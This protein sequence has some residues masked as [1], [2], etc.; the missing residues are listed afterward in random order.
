M[1]KKSI[2]RRVTA[3]FCLFAFAL[4]SLN[5][6]EV[7]QTKVVRASS[8][9]TFPS[10]G[11][12]GLGDLLNFIVLFVALASGDSV[13]SCT[14]DFD[15]LGL[16]PKE[17]LQQLYPR[18][19]YFCKYMTDGEY[20]MFLES[21]N[22]SV[23]NDCKEPVLV[24][25]VPEEIWKAFEQYAGVESGYYAN[26]ATQ[27][28]GIYI[29]YGTIIGELSE[30]IKVVSQN[31]D[32]DQT[33]SPSGSPK[34]DTSEP[35]LPSVPNPDSAI[36]ALSFSDAEFAK[37][38]QTSFVMA[39]LRAVMGAFAKNNQ[40]N[41]DASSDVTNNLANTFSVLHFCMKDG[42]FFSQGVSAL[43]MFINQ[44]RYNVLISPMQ[45]ENHSSK[46]TVKFPGCQNGRFLYPIF[47]W[48]NDKLFFTVYTNKTA[49][50]PLI[51]QYLFDIPSFL[52]QKDGKVVNKTQKLIVYP[53]S[54][55]KFMIT[56]ETFIDYFIRR[57]SLAFDE[58]KNNGF[59]EFPDE[60]SYEKFVAAVNSGTLTVPEL[61]DLL[62]HKWRYK[63]DS[64]YPELNVASKA[65]PI[66]MQKSA[67]SGNLDKYKNPAGKINFN[68][69]VKG[70]SEK[71]ASKTSES[72]LDEI[73][74]NPQ[75][76]TSTEKFPKPIKA[77]ASGTL[78]DAWEGNEPKPNPNPDPNPS[79]NPNPGPDPDPNPGT[80]P[81]TE[82]GTNPGTNPDTKP[83]DID[84]EKTK[85]P[86]LLK[87]FPFCVPWD[88]IALVQ[89]L[90]AKATPP[91]FVLPFKINNKHLKV[92]ESIEIDFSR[93]EKQAEICR[94]FFR[95][96]FILAL[97]L[98][99]RSIIKG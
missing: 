58:Y 31:Q 15:S 8:V 86:Q 25:G 19:G 54:K 76:G 43:I 11:A 45:S 73:I 24:P 20:A 79:P 60:D 97:I 75:P 93:Y 80:E 44:T 29:D 89:V 81:G 53:L 28:G 40:A 12:N 47:Y 87:K 48:K 4:A 67:E 91:K 26:G 50:N 22:A 41:L 72:P 71:T 27:P 84:P 18:D 57:F 70:V 77:P 51:G 13:S 5:I 46:D 10:S 56:D 30:F 94:W 66:S 92:D 95:I 42:A 96:M 55:E 2:M 62:S 3:L 6:G 36:N 1:V 90:S 7:S 37:L 9:S 16:T 78:P 17:Y 49:D 99:T 35:Q 98:L 63:T 82:P 38:I 21:F 61:V 52:E 33:P 39:L 64:V 65:Y 32:P 88:L 34:P 74:G 83:E 69:I 68:S 14:V 59:L 23:Y 85:T